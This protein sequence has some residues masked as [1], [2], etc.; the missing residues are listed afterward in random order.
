[1]GKYETT[2]HG[3]S[4]EDLPKIQHFSFHN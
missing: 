1:M 3:V 4:N 2:K